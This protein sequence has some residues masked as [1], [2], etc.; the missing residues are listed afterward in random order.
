MSGETLFKVCTAAASP[1]ATV[2]KPRSSGS[3]VLAGASALYS[4]QGGRFI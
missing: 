1:V 2:E 4:L 3:P